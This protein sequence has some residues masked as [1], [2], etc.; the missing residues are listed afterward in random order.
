M[1]RDR[2]N[3]LIFQEVNRLLH[4][5]NG[6]RINNHVAARIFVQRFY[7]KSGLG[8]GIAFV[9]HVTQIGAVKAGNVLV[10]IA[11]AELVND[12]VPDPACGA[13]GKGS[14]GKVR[15]MDAQRAELPVIGPELVSPF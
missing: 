6:R 11:Q 2:R 9:H 8:L 15:E 3:S 7:Q 12:V 5:I 1:V 13:G 10:R 14:D 4:L